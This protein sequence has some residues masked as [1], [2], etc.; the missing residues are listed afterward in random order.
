MWRLI[1]LKFQQI[2]KRGDACQRLTLTTFIPETVAELEFG[3][4]LNCYEPNRL[5]ENFFTARNENQDL[6]ISVRLTPVL[7]QF[8][9]ITIKYFLYL[10]SEITFVSVRKRRPYH[11][12]TWCSGGSAPRIL[13]QGIR[14][15]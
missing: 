1:F 2:K 5:L 10:Q 7:I 9:S 12:G 11:K 13:N 6:Q 14:W 4:I 15:N 8:L 3:E